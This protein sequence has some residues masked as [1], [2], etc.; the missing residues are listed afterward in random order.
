MTHSRFSPF[1]SLSQL[2]ALS[3][4]CLVFCVSAVKAA[5][6]SKL[7]AFLNVTGFDVALDSIRN[8][9]GSAPDM[10]GMDPGTFGADWTRLTA[11]VF[12][13]AV[14]R[15]MAI[16]ILEAT[17]TDDLLSHAAAFYAS[18]LGQRLVQAENSSHMV[19]DSDAKQ[20]AGSALVAQMVQEGSPRLAMLKRMNQAIDTSDTSTRALQEIQI[21]FLM[22]ASAAGVVEL[23]MDTD[24]LRALM[25]TQEGQLRRA[26]QQSALAGAAYTYQAFS[27]D[28]VEAYAEALENPSMQSVYEL[29]NAVQYEIMA[30]RF[31]ALAAQ[32]AELTPVQD[33]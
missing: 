31:E 21:R 30:N 15:G 23:R 2:A 20:E 24:E 5:D 11:T 9:A 14:M 18:D 25:K 7:E 27:D 13:T 28:E 6:R 12:D 19:A 22:S 8:S 10:L 32:M 4:L 17:L 26:I 16:D 33:I 29:M 3:L 1:S